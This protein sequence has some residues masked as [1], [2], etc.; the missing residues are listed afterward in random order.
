MPDCTGCERPLGLHRSRCHHC[1]ACADC[2]DCGDPCDCVTSRAEV[3]RSDCVKF[4]RDELGMDPEED[5]D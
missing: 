1:G 2:C 5:D 3:A 4:D